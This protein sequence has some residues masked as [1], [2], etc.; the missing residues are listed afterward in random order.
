MYLLIMSLVLCLI[1][2]T[3]FSVDLGPYRNI[4]LVRFMPAGFSS[5][6][7]IPCKIVVL[8]MA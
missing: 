2:N 5:L 6:T 7:P 4:T 8:Q 3:V 1:L